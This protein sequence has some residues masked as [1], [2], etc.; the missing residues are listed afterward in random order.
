MYNKNAVTDMK[1]HITKKYLSE[2]MDD[3]YNTLYDHFS[4]QNKYKNKIFVNK[5]NTDINVKLR[6]DKSVQL[7]FLSLIQF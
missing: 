4:Y 5:K 2:N 6:M 3:F 7:R 1:I